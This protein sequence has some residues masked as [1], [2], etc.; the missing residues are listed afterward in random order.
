MNIYYCD[1]SKIDFNDNLIKKYNI[2]LTKEES[3]RLLN[4]KIPKSK[5]NFLFGRLIIRQELSKYLNCSI[6]DIIFHKTKFGRLELSKKF[7]NNNISFNISHSKNIVAVIICNNTVGI[8]VEY[9]KNKDLSKIANFTFSPDEIEYLD[10]L[11]KNYPKQK[12]LEAFYSY[13][14]L[15]EAFI[16]LKGGSILNKN[17]KFTFNL[18]NNQ[19][20]NNFQNYTPQNYI[21]KDVN[22]Q[23]IFSTIDTKNNLQFRTFYLQDD[24]IL[25]YAAQI[26]N[27]KKFTV[28]KLYF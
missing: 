2:F 28:N 18:K 10:Y 19:K 6:D 5:R 17:L 15:H 11:L 21:N 4:I 1:L 9:M 25:S 8:D 12:Y 3:K 13:W 23:E 27:N 24:Y 16:K 14:T 26:S 7:A 22:Y 20:F